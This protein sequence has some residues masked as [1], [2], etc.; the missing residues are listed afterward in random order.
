MSCDNNKQTMA[1]CILFKQSA[2]VIK[3][4]CGI[5][6]NETAAVSNDLVYIH[7]YMLESFRYTYEY[8]N[9][10]K[11]NWHFI[12]CKNIIT[13]CLTMDVWIF[14]YYFRFRLLVLSLKGLE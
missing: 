5:N 9:F 11:E 14:T 10:L 6:S 4:K 2:K 7:M 8:I 3:G 13:L 1:C 12:V